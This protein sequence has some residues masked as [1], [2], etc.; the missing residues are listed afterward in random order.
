MTKY[1]VESISEPVALCTDGKLHLTPLASGYYIQEF[2]SMTEAAIAILE[3]GMG[4]AFNLIILP[5]ISQTYQI[6]LL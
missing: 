3:S 4:C 1:T 5:K 2:N 6:P